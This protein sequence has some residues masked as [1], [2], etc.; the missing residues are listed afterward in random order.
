MTTTQQPTNRPVTGTWVLR[1]WIA[2]A[3]IPVFLF[4]AILMGY[5][6]YGVFGYVP[7]D[8][9]VP[10]WVELMVGVVTLAVFL[11]P[12]AAAV[13]YGWIANKAH[14]R[15]GLVPLAIGGVLGIWMTVVTVITV[16]TSV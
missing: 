6:I 10:A 8:L 12:G 15:R 16:A 5:L 3:L 1:S 13:F 9:D 11:V 14:D 2:V 4:A 7:E